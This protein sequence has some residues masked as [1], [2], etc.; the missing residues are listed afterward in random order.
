MKT[1]D[2]YVY[3]HKQIPVMMVLSLFPGLGY[4]FLGW[5]N[6]IY[7]PAL[8][9]YLVVILISLRGYSLYKIFD[10]DTMSEAQLESWYKHTSVFLYL[11]F[12]LWA[13]IFIAYAPETESGMHYIAIFTE[14]GAATVAAAILFPDKKLYKSTILTLIIPLIIY[15]SLIGSISVVFL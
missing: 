9:W 2:L 7:I 5:I 14:I 15:F 11:F 12:L 8:V 4:I 3:I 13:V 10:L 1:N 6:D